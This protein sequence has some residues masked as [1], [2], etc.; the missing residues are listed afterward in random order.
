MSDHAPLLSAWEGALPAVLKLMGT[1][2]RGMFRQELQRFLA[3]ARFSPEGADAMVPVLRELLLQAVRAAEVPPALHATRTGVTDRAAL[4]ALC[5]HILA[6]WRDA[7]A[8]AEGTSTCDPTGR[9]GV[10]FFGPRL[11]GKGREGAVSHDDAD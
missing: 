8:A 5:E 10:V 6:C 4:S 9:S 3:T 11:G 1:P 2:Q 7:E